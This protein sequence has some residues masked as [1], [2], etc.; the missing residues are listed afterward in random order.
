[1]T[2]FTHNLDS[3][4]ARCSRSSASLCST[5]SGAMHSRA[6]AAGTYSLQHG[7]GLDSDGDHGGK[8][9]RGY[10]TVARDGEHLTTILGHQNGVLELSAA[11]AI[12]SHRGPV[13]V[14]HAQ[15]GVAQGQHGLD[16]EGHARLHDGA[17]AGVEVV[18]DLHRTV[19]LGTDAVTDELAHDPEVELARVRLDREADHVERKARLDRLDRLV[20]RH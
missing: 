6:S 3:L 11:P 15:I 20:E 1:M 18:G 5:N 19:E 8:D 14:P 9:V 12:Q 2:S 7:V 13:V 4:A 17:G 16:G 10:L